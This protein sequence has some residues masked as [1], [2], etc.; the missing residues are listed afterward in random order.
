MKAYRPSDE[1]EQPFRIV[2][3]LQRYWEIDE[4]VLKDGF[5]CFPACDQR[6]LVRLRRAGKPSRGGKLRKKYPYKSPLCSGHD[7]QR[8]RHGTKGMKPLQQ[9]RRK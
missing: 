7:K 6:R 3:E 4:D 5:C 9:R 8:Q 1:G 2:D